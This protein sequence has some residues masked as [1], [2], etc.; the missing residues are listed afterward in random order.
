MPPSFR[1][2]VVSL[3]DSLNHRLPGFHP[4]RDDENSTFAEGRWLSGAPKAP[5]GW[6]ETRSP[7]EAGRGG[8]IAGT[9]RPTYF[10]LFRFGMRHWL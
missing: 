6:S 3:A 5:G 9:L 8:A 4:V 10:E 2:P 1:F 7:R